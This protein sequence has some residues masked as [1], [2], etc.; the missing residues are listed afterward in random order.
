MVFGR[1]VPLIAQLGKLFQRCNA[2]YGALGEGLATL[3]CIV[4]IPKAG[5]SPHRN[6]LLTVGQNHT[7]PCPRE[8]QRGRTN[9]RK[10]LMTVLKISSFVLNAL[11][12]ASGQLRQN[13]PGSMLGLGLIIILVAHKSTAN[14]YL[15]FVSR[16]AL[17]RS[18]LGS[19]T[20]Q[21]RRKHIYSN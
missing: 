16:P 1:P 6:R 2:L 5:F 15:R 8:N 7:P 12:V 21:D 19:G 4:V 18:G 11:N 20:L 9:F 10:L 3:P 13:G 17:K 14:N